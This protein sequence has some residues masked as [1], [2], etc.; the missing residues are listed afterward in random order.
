[1]RYC[2]GR[3]YGRG[4]QET[5]KGDEHSITKIKFKTW[6]NSL[7]RQYLTNPL[8]NRRLNYATLNTSVPIQLPSPPSH[9]LIQQHPPPHPALYTATT[10]SPTAQSSQ[11]RQTFL[12]YSSA[13]VSQTQSQTHATT[14]AKGEQTTRRLGWISGFRGAGRGGWFRRRRGRSGACTLTRCPFV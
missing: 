12:V 3:N 10:S 4:R 8:A 14:A 6:Y 7:Y 1:M 2:F 13:P 11:T 5:R 9:P